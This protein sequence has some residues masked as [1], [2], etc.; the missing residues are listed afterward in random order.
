MNFAIQEDIK[1]I[2]RA[3]FI[4][5]YFNFE[6]KASEL[7][8]MKVLQAFLLCCGLHQVIS[9]SYGFRRDDICKDV[10][11]DTLVIKDDEESCGMF[12]A[13][14][15]GVANRFKCFSDSVYSNGTAICL[16]CKENMEEDYYEDSGNP[17]GKKTTKKKFT[18]KQTKRTKPPTKKYN[19]T[20]P[21]PPTYPPISTGKLQKVL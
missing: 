12:I 17:Y 1:G 20:R 2:T 14:V 10:D 5:I 3:L 16:T 15:G 18:Y 8:D 7:R 6:V 4:I 19:V 21:P 13:C 9:R 11:S